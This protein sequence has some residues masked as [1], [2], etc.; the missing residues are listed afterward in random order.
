MSEEFHAPLY[1][2]SSEQVSPGPSDRLHLDKT[3]H[4]ADLDCSRP[5]IA[6][7]SST[8]VYSGT[9]CSSNECTPDA[10]NTGFQYQQYV[11]GSSLTFSTADATNG[12]TVLLEYNCPAAGGTDS[13]YAVE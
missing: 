1:S 11:F 4:P 13:T 3:K 7:G 9:P 12:V 6:D 10:I 8:V 5:L 2:R